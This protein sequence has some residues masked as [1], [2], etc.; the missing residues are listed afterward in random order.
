MKELAEEEES[1]CRRQGGRTARGAGVL[2][3]H[4]MEATQR[5][6]SRS[7]AES[8]QRAARATGEC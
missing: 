6:L 7:C 1:S 3:M 8:E 5:Q 2:K 4:E